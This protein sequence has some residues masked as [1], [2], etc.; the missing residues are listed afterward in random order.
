M[1]HEYL[2]TSNEERFLSVQLALTNRN[3][4]HR[5]RIRSFPTDKEGKNPVLYTIFTAESNR[6]VTL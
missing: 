4:P 3:I 6:F 5:I 2:V 1:Q